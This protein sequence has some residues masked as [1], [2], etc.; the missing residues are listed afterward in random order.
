MSRRKDCA[1]RDSRLLRH[2]GCAASWTR[3]F[4]SLVNCVTHTS[5]RVMWH[6][7][8]RH[9]FSAAVTCWQNWNLKDTLQYYWSS[10]FP[11]YNVFVICEINILCIQQY[12]SHPDRTT[13]RSSKAKNKRKNSFHCHNLFFSSFHTP[14]VV[15]VPEHTQS[16]T[17]YW[18]GRILTSNLCVQQCMCVIM[19]DSNILHKI[20]RRKANWI[21]HILRRNCLLKRT[22]EGI[23]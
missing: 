13:T 3:S 7:A 21:G 1:F 11:P 2:R 14:R 9:A 6:V 19:E 22:V 20:K 15:H 5:L 8:W 4:G 18:N 12:V 10:L 16:P 17:P 23:R